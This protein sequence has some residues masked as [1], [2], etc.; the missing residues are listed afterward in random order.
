MISKKEK[1]VIC[2]LAQ[3]YHVKRI[4][5]FGSNLDPHRKE[6]QDI[7]LAVEG[8][9]PKYFFKFYGDLLFALKKSVDL[10]DLSLKGKFTQ[11]V[12]KEGVVLYG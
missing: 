2:S 6:T 11:L 8:I 10:V 5:L 9:S 7:D 12:K 1:S 4:F 3:K